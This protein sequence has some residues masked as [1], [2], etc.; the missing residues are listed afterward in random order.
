MRHRIKGRR[1]GRT[2]SH[3]KA[4]GKNLVSSLFKHGRIET[5]LPKAKEYRPMAE[6]LITKAKT[7]DLHRVRHAVKL[8]G[9]K[10]AVARLFDDIGPAMKDRPGGYTRIVKLGR[11]RLGDQGTRVLLELVDHVPT[12]PGG[13]DAE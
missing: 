1:L 8:L 2:A 13:D 12:S 11:R 10:A 7:K 9:D 3:R 5:T 4:L 6:K